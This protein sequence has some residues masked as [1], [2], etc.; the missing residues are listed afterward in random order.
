MKR[1]FIVTMG[2]CGISAGAKVVADDIDAILGDNV[3]RTS[4]YRAVCLRTY[5]YCRER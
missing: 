5:S 2:T 3:K 4:V 1:D